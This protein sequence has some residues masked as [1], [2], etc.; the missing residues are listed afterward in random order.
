MT[1]QPIVRV[2]LDTPLRRLFDYLSDGQ[3]V[4]VGCRVRVPFGRQ[5]LVGLV[6]ALA[7]ESDLPADKLRPVTAVL[8]EQPLLDEPLLNLDFGN[9]AEN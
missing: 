2:A 5:T 1:L 4:A 8:D 9:L 7:T 3:P 6:V